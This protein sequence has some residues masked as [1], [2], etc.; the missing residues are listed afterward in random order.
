MRH[1]RAILLDSKVN[2]ED[3]W[4]KQLPF[5]SR[6]MNNHIHSSTG[7]TPFNLVYGREGNTFIDRKLNEVERDY[8]NN[9]SAEWLEKKFESQQR[10]I[11]LAREH[12]AKVNEIPQELLEKQFEDPKIGEWVLV[13]KSDVMNN[14]KLAPIKEGPFQVQ[15]KDRESN[16]PDIY[17]IFDHVNGS[18]FKVH[19]SRLSKFVV[20]NNEIDHIPQIAMK[21]K[22]MFE[23]EHVLNHKNGDLNDIKTKN[24]ILFFIKWKDYSRS[25]NTWEPF[26]N[27]E[28]NSVLHDYLR[29]HRAHNWIP[30][31][32]L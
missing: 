23:V 2:I 30:K 7:F 20:R 5:V 25:E 15:D 29:L 14:H 4:A 27:L 1:L 9:P 12:L 21:R 17:W 13:R 28:N 18:S 10:I 22:R 16:C 11:N 24:K 8:K 19:V 31:R 6:I 32:F 3:D 26:I